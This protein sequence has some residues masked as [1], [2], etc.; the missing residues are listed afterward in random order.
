MNVTSVLLDGKLVADIANSDIK[1]ILDK[2]LGRCRSLIFY[3]DLDL[4][5]KVEVRMVWV[6]GLEVCSAHVD[7]VLS[8]V[9]RVKAAKE[10][11]SISDVAAAAICL[12]HV[13]L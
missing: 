12:P 2:V 10:I 9:V 7:S 5:R 8:S 11:V 6:F 1:F 13:L 3:S 4:V